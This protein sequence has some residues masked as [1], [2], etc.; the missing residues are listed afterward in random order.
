ENRLRANVANASHSCGPKTDLGR[1]IA[2]RNATR[3]GLCST[4]VVLPNEDPA[5][6][7][8][9]RD[10]WFEH[11][12][13]ADPAHVAALE[14]LV[15]A[16]WRLRRC[17]RYEAAVLSKR[18]R[19]AEQAYDL[20]ERAAAE[21]LGLRLL[22]GPADGGPRPPEDD[23]ALLVE[24]LRAT[25]AG[26]AGLLG[27]GGGLSERLAHVGCGDAAALAVATRLLGGRP[28]DA[29][30][31]PTATHL[32]AAG[33]A[34]H[35]EPRLLCE[36]WKAEHPGRDVSGACV[37]AL[38][39]K[40]A[41]GDRAGGRAAL[42]RLGAGE[43]GRLEERKRAELDPRAALERAA[44]AELALFDD[45]PSGVLLRRYETACEREYHKALAEVLKFRKE[46]PPAAEFEA[47]PE[48]PA[49][50]AG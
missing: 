36:D 37:R 2:S 22:G 47:D 23:P 41:L 27:R 19:D 35:P 34:A 44:A 42:R 46:R 31:D 18:V 43:V 16:A 5:E 13:P 4:Q 14:S 28:E 29:A 26:T 6:F 50:Q 3:H 10:A 1:S 8:A 7:Q 49:S 20:A 40:E 9:L 24:Q 48:P 15:L 33:L 45:S 39:L 32:F 17:K 25:A 11:D 30:L 21:A 38:P 12:R